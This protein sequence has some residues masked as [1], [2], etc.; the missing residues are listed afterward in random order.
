MKGA[1]RRSAHGAAMPT[2]PL[3][4]PHWR[5]TLSRLQR[6]W[7]H[8]NLD[9][10]LVAHIAGWD[11]PGLAAGADLD[12]VLVAAGLRSAR[13]SDGPRPG[14][15]DGGDGERVAGDRV[16]AALTVVAVD[17]PLAARVVLQRLLP[18]LSAMARR[19]SRSVDEHLRHT[20][21]LLG[22]AWTVIRSRPLR[23]RR[24]FVAAQLLRAIEHQVFVRQ[25]RRL[26]VHEL[27]EPAA[28]DVPV[29]PGGAAGDPLLEIVEVLRV[30]GVDALR[31]GDVALISAL[32]CSDRVRD[33]ARRLR[34]SERTVRN[35]REAMVGRLRQALAA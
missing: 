33:A 32:L 1:G 9:R 15:A 13:P 28:M 27:V 22:A 10:R 31:D 14:A 11:L 24:D 6:E 23:P 5:F 3:T 30:A 7:D 25:Q 29:E 17:D 20:D 16:L 4:Q 21:E 26:L 19:R 2:S 8:L 18:G 12:G 35:H 34:V